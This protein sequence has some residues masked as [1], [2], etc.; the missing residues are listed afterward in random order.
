MGGRAEGEEVG[1]G[2]PQD[3]GGPCRVT[4]ERTEFVVR[5]GWWGRSVDSPDDFSFPSAEQQGPCWRGGGRK[6]SQ[7]G[8]WESGW[9]KEMLVASGLH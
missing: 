3:E 2:L 4:G 8:W 1:I 9:A 6:D 7:L 5:M